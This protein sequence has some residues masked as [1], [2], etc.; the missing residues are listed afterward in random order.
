MS[1]CGTCKM[2]VAKVAMLLSGVDQS[3]GRASLPASM[4][5]RKTWQSVLVVIVL[6]T[7]WTAGGYAQNHEMRHWGG[8]A[9]C[10]HS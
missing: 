3:P 7:L 4:Q 9:A 6:V 10:H 1:C 8:E 2:V 5:M